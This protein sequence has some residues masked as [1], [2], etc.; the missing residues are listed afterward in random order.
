MAASQERKRFRRF[1]LYLIDT[2]NVWRVCYHHQDDSI[3]S[4]VNVN[5][6]ITNA[7]KILH[8]YNERGTLETSGQSYERHAYMEL[9]EVEV[10]VCSNGTYGDCRQFCYCKDGPCDFITGQCPGSGICEIGFTGQHCQTDCSSIG[11]YG[12]NCSESCSARHC[13]NRQMCHR[14]TGRC[15]DGCQD[16][17]IAPTCVKHCANDFRYGAGCSSLC[18]DRKCE[19]QSDCDR[20][21]GTCQNGCQPGWAGGDCTH[22]P[23]PSSSLTI[24]TISGIAAGCLI[25]VIVLV[26]LGVLLM[27]R[28][29]NTAKENSSNE[30]AV[31]PNRE[32]QSK[33][34]TN[35]YSNVG[36]DKDDVPDVDNTYMVMGIED[37]HNEYYNVNC[38]PVATGIEV[39]K[40][41]AIFAK[42]SEEDFLKEFN[43]LPAGFTTT[44][45]ES[46]KPENRLK[47]KFQGYYPYDHN[48]VT[49]EL[50]PEI[51]CSDY[52]NASFISGC[53]TEKRYIAAQA[54]KDITLL[55]FW[56]MIWQE[57][58][59][60]IVILTNLVEKGKEKCFQYWP[61]TMR[62]YGDIKV[63]LDE[64]IKKTFYTMRLLKTIHKKTNEE[65][66]IKQFHFT[67]WPD[68][69]TPD[70]M[71]LI[72]FMWLVKS[73]DK[74]RSGPMLV[75]CSAGIGRT[76][77]YISID[78]L[79]DEGQKTGKVDVKRFV[80][81]L[82]GERKNMIQTVEQYTFI[83]EALL[84]AFS[85]GNT[86]MSRQQLK[87]TYSPDSFKIGSKSL[88]ELSQGKKNAITLLFMEHSHH[89]KQFK[90][91]QSQQ[92]LS[93]IIVYCE[94]LD[95]ASIDDETVW[96]ILFD[97]HCSTVIH[98]VASLK[99][100]NDL[101]LSSKNSKNFEFTELNTENVP[102]E[103]T[104]TKAQVEKENE[105]RNLQLYT[106]YNWSGSLPNSDMITVINVMDMARQDQLV[107]QHPVLVLQ[108][109]TC[110]DPGLFCILFNVLQ[111]IAMTGDV[112]VINNARRVLKHLPKTTISKDIINYCYRMAL[113]TDNTNSIYANI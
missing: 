78:T 74:S 94:S 47:N 2:D 38:L 39:G 109:S 105:I 49:L 64:Q 68:H 104:V 60:T 101:P 77:S 36:F 113:F 5:C 24:G 82:R 37:N 65:R 70:T 67:S 44:Y 25:A 1:T 26:I 3:Q 45:E 8:V 19:G 12:V 11:N 59:H 18:H 85:Y 41:A 27:R 62:E 80:T 89:V 95:D 9:C 29:R 61:E 79:I 34:V 22:I 88:E 107:S 100:S 112:E 92:L 20:T 75:H 99:E 66:M 32:E 13:F 58:C 16:G 48:R 17:W 30:I 4:I 76:G 97:Y 23:M 63:T 42:T 55:D 83:Y 93:G 108:S 40:L 28:L 43:E 81:Q 53:V 98:L 90:H 46:Q 50:L 51:P 71:N 33:S 6:N 57:G 106:L 87:E 52:I 56:R 73:W 96:N 84:E 35:M 10:Y 69:G 110:V 91:Q 72:E 111:G 21:N 54:P 14:V 31:L 15:L 102:G 7:T 103:L 86:I